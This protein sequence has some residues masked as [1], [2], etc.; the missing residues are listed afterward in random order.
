[1]CVSVYIYVFLCVYIYKHYI[2]K[3]AIVSSRRLFE[4]FQLPAKYS[5]D[6][7]RYFVSLGTSNDIPRNQIWEHWC[8][9]QGGPQ[10]WSGR[11]R[12]I[13][14]PL[15]FDPRTV[16]VPT[17]LYSLYLALHQIIGIDWTCW[18]CVRNHVF[19]SWRS[20]AVWERTNVLGP[21]SLVPSGS[22]T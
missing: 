5:R 10:G 20:H 7:S 8:R 21:H 11:A 2:Y 1:M 6:I 9:R 12:E 4:Y 18:G 22:R 13:S 17:T 15:G 19:F 14:L 16:A 3:H